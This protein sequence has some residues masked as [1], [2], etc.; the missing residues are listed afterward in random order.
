MKIIKLRHTTLL[1]VL[2]GTLLVPAACNLQAEAEGE[3]EVDY[4][5][6]TFTEGDARVVCEEVITPFCAAFAMCNPVNFDAFYADETDCVARQTAACVTTMVMPG[7][8]VT[9]QELIDCGLEASTCEFFESGGGTVYDSCDLKGALGHAKTCSS[10]IQCASG[11]C[12]DPDEGCGKC[13]SLKQEGEECSDGRLDMFCAAGLSCSDASKTCVPE[14]AVGEAC[15]AD[16]ACDDWGECVDG[17]CESRGGEGEPCNWQ[18]NCRGDRGCFFGT[19][20]SFELVEE[21]ATCDEEGTP[22]S[23]CGNGY[24]A[25]PDDTCVSYLAI[26]DPCDEQSSCGVHAR[27]GSSG[28]CELVPPSHNTD[29]CYG[30]DD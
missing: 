27:C 6:S 29:L 25:F 21:G 23:I 1:T 16:T 20:V 24:C 30:A 19:C 28:T 13:L 12:T 10:S 15:G 5:V 8:A 17:V 18:R 7:I 22:P 4:P 9:K 3:A 2:F 11:Y 14:V 26:G